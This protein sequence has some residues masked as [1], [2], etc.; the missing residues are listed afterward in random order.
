MYSNLV[1]KGIYCD[2]R[3]KYF[4]LHKVMQQNSMQIKIMFEIFQQIITYIV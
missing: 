4:T 1:N 2:T 3:C